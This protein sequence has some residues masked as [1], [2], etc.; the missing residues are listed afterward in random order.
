MMRAR[1]L[2]TTT[3]ATLATLTGM[4]ALS[5][6]S[7]SAAI[8]HP[9]LS[10]I[11]E[12]PTSSKANVTGPLSSPQGLALVSGDLYVADTGGNAVTDEFNSSGDFLAQF[13]Y[14]LFTGYA[15]TVAASRATGE[16]YVA[17]S[18][19]VD[20][21]V[22]NS[23]GK[24]LATWYGDDTPSKSF[25]GYDFVAVDNSTSLS[26][27]AAGDIYVADTGNKVVDV[28]K[29]GVEG[30]ETYVTQL[31]GTTPEAPFGRPYGIAVD[32]TTGDVYVTDE[33]NHTV[34]VFAPKSGNK[35]EYL[36]TLT[37]PTGGTFDSIGQVAVDPVDGDV[38]VSD[39]A[40]KV[41]YQFGPTGEYLGYIANTATGQLE[42]PVGVAVNS[43]EDV[44][45][46]E[47]SAGTIDEFGPGV[48]VPDTSTGEASKIARVSAT[49]E[50]TVNPDKTKAKYYFQW[51][52]SNSLEHTTTV[53]AAEGETTIVTSANLT[54][55]KAASTYSY[56][57][58]AEN[59]NGK[60]YGSVR[61]FATPEPIESINT[62][63]ATEVTA[64]GATLNG[65]VSP[66]G[67]AT[68]CWFEYEGGSLPTTLTTEESFGEESKIE[69]PAKTVSGLEPNT[70]YRDLLAC[71]NGFGT[72]HGPYSSFRTLEAEP[73]V[74]SESTEYV[75]RKSAE[76]VAEINPQNSTTSYYFEYG[77]STAYGYKT[78]VQET[79]GFGAVRVEAIARELESDAVYHFRVIAKSAAGV[80]IGPDATFTS[81]SLT[82]PVVTTGGVSEVTQASATVEGV[83]STEGLI[84]SYGFEVST[85]PSQFGPPTGLGSIGAGFNEATATLALHGLKASTT[86]YYKL[87]GTSTE[88]T[89]E[90]AIEHFTTTAYPSDQIS[91]EQLPI[92]TEP[93]VEWPASGEFV[94]THTE[95]KAAVK[96]LKKV[97][98]HKKG[99]RKKKGKK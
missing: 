26:D 77:P 74:V 36:R 51:G 78:S 2:T 3:V 1:R 52:E 59:A 68:K 90:G 43:V 81:G 22:F 29:A 4:L 75:V 84:T 93:L 76:L 12:V 38:Y 14:N 41:V 33:E 60:N 73:A 39:P 71:K 48:V 82:P 99:K 66:N 98:K 53:E 92:L 56:R 88:G 85:S 44:F 25:G 7:V 40:A 54:G 32:E 49:V 86:Y 11:T 94:N 91:V 65:E 46:T 21:N 18:W 57:M 15:T 35:Y 19:Y 96:K 16:V 79:G 9:Y 10:D 63:G 83:V 87:L 5:S 27:P 37:G 17:D 72:S 42:A 13:G 31:T 62:L 69:K 95:P 6:G 64:T 50:G 30:K 28:F 70:E 20:V 24:D 47:A 97:K 89:T 45:V 8:T 23:T 58:V 80:A 34:D 67:F 61:S 55:L